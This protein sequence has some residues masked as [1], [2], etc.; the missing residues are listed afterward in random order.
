MKFTYEKLEPR[1][2]GSG[3]TIHVFYLEDSPNF[4]IIASKLGVKI[5]GETQLFQPEEGEVNMPVEEFREL[6]NRL[7]SAFS[8]AYK[9]QYKEI[10]DSAGR[11]MLLEGK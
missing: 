1:I 8:L 7:A 10:K 4:K 11:K 2:I 9:E 5:V 3:P 6:M